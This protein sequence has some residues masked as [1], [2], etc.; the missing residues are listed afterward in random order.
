MRIAVFTNQFPARVSTFFARDVTALRKAGVEI[1]VFTLYFEERRLWRFVPAAHRKQIEEGIRI[2]YPTKRGLFGYGAR[3]LIG[4]TRTSLPWCASVAVSAARYGAPQIGKSLYAVAHG[5][6]CAAEGTRPFDHILAYWGNY[7]ATSA[8]VFRDLTSTMTPFSLFLHAGID[9]YRDQIVLERKLR[10][11]K[12]IIVVCDFNRRFLQDKYPA[13]YGE[14][15]HKIHLHHL[16]IELSEYGYT[17]KRQASDRVIAVGHFCKV[18][19]FDVLIRAIGSLRSRGIAV[20]ADFAG[21][22]PELAPCRKLTRQLALSDRIRFLGW[23]S[24]D[25]VRQKIARAAVLVHPSIGLGD[26]VPTV[27]KEAMSLGTAVVAS[28]VAGIPE[29]LDGG[30]CG[31]LAEPGDPEKLAD[32]IANVVQN[33]VFRSQLAERARRRAETLFDIWANGR[34]LAELLAGQGASESTKTPAVA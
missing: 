26:A 22:G 1:E 18:K 9:L 27:I 10:A 34:R 32:G 23:L 24:P 8:L 12:H 4:R 31:V 6:S 21:D 3:A 20:E 19:G 16:G 11:A 5:A 14:I 13:L 7:A 15:E 33:P 25:Q 2:H 29:L 28:D 30:N 17:P